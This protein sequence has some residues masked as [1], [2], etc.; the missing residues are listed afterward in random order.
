MN[1]SDVIRLTDS[2]SGAR[3]A[4]VPAVGFNC[5]QFSVPVRGRPCEVLW[6]ADDFAAGGRPSASGNP[7]LFPFAGRL[8]GTS[9][10][11]DGRSFTLAA[12][13]GRGNAIHGFVLDRPWEVP[14]REEH[15]A[16]GLFRSTNFPE[17][18]D[19]WPSAW[20]LECR[21]E[22]TGR[23]LRSWLTA[24]NTGAEPLPFSLGTHP[25][26]RLPLGPEGSAEDCVLRVPAKEY[27]E[28][29]EM[30]PTGR[31]LPAEGSRGVARGLPLA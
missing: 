9:V 6:S 16:V 27:W 1:S 13:D 14:R 10:V 12:G 21:Y 20:E 17:L 2:A 7:L 29:A 11:L 19:A 3:A 15:G 18:K 23:E 26:F 24:R 25:Y 4:I 30:L 22:L 5:C 31:L 8:R 28:L